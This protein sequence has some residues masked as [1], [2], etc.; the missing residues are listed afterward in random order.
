MGGSMEA[1]LTT[2]WSD[3]LSI[4]QEIGRTSLTATEIIN[5]LHTRRCTDQCVFR[6]RDQ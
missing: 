4:P 6:L 2:M 5:R 3:V 1:V